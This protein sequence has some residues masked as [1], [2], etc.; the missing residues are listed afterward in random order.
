MDEVTR[1]KLRKVNTSQIVCNLYR[2]DDC[3]VTPS[4]WLP[5]AQANPMQ[6]AAKGTSERRENKPNPQ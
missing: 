4:A 3:S 2:A 6:K 1:K 5:S